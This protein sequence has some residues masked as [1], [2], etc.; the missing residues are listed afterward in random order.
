M[1]IRFDPTND[2]IL[3]QEFSNELEDIP[4]VGTE[5]Q[6]Q[7]AKAIRHNAVVANVKRF[8]LL[9]DGKRFRHEGITTEW[10]KACAAGISKLASIEDAKFWID[11][12][13]AN[14]QLLMSKYGH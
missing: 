13:D 10:L 2:M 6:V 1:N 8:N 9:V 4:M 5:K 3:D 14:P 12:K 7:W 11:N